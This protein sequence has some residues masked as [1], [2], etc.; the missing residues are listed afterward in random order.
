LIGFVSLAVSEKSSLT[1]KKQCVAL[2]K[3]FPSLQ[4][5]II[6]QDRAAVLEKAIV[7]DDV[8]KMPY[9]YLT[10][11]PIKGNSLLSIPILSSPH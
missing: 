10:E 1:D 6:L 2:K 11:Q 8:E 3:K 4:G 5:K 9:D 7:G